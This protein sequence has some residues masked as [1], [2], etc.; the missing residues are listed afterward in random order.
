MILRLL[1]VA[2]FLAVSLVTSQ[3]TAGE[4]RTALPLTATLLD[5]TRFS[6]AE[7]RGKVVLINFWA[8]WCEPCRKEMPALDAF[9]RRH[10]E[11]GLTMLAISLDEPGDAGA[12]RD[13]M[14]AYTF[15]AALSVQARY[16]GYGRIWRVP[17][18]FVVDRQGRLRDD[19]MR[20][21]LLVD[22]TFLEQRVAPLLEP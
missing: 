4:P 6:L 19:L 1:R 9:Y 8:T 18:T 21:T 22:E 10:R 17:M 16:S 13:V 7:N 20:D 15:P 3:I 14:R 11:H 2:L 12:V 5:G